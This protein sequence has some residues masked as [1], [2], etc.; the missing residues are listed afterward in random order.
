MSCGIATNR[1]N[2]DDLLR[3]ELGTPMPYSTTRSSAPSRLHRDAS[4][5]HRGTSAFPRVWWDC[6]L[7]SRP[8]VSVRETTSK[9]FGAL[10]AP[11][12]LRYWRAH[13]RLPNDIP[14]RKTPTGNTPNGDKA[15]GAWSVPE[16]VLRARPRLRSCR[17]LSAVFQKAD[18]NTW[19]RAS[20]FSGTRRFFEI[21]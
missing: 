3:L 9:Y 21:L 20:C 14:R 15:H 5:N 13:E 18:H 1:H 10:H 17:P 6:A 4:R 8:S 19:R 2:F 12:G 7:Y 16:W 11:A